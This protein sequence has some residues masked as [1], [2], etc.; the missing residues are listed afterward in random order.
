MCPSWSQ[1]YDLLNM[2]LSLLCAMVGGANGIGAAI[3][4]RFVREHATVSALR[5]LAL[6]M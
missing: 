2:L 1:V 3:C 6:R 5:T 4:E